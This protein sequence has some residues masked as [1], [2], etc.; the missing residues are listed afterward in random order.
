MMTTA[1]M[2]FKVDPD[3][4]KIMEAFRA[5]PAYFGDAFARAWF[6][7]CHRDM[8]PK[9][10]YLGPDVP[11]EDLIWQDP[12]PAA[13]R[14]ELTDADIETLKDQIAAS[15]LSV[16]DL[17]RTAWASAATYRGSDHRGGANG[18]RIRLAPQTD[19]DVNEP[20]KLAKVLQVYEGIKAVVAA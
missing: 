5:D 1:D 9:I 10:R 6:K 18:G 3:Y 17:V 7:L 20:H 11:A 4:R 13:H 12:I 16:A 2:A 15:G 14:P 8:G 19:W